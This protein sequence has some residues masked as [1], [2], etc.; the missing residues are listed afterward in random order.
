MSECPRKCLQF[1]VEQDIYSD[2]YLCRKELLLRNFLHYVAF[3]GFL[4]QIAQIVNFF[5]R[6]NKC[7][8]VLHL[9]YILWYR[10][11]FLEQKLLGA[12]C[13]K[14]NVFFQTFWFFNF[15]LK[16]MHYYILVY[17]CNNG[18]ITDFLFLGFFSVS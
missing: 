8:N 15:F 6:W 18:F 11:G 12:F 4:E 10:Y 16:K 7:P 14:K 13:S 5:C 3:F 2:I 17:Q 9:Y 1:V